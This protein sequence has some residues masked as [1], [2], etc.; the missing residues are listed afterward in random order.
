MRR[1]QR[2]VENDGLGG[3]ANKFNWRVRD[4]PI[5]RYE[6]HRGQHGRVG[7]IRALFVIVAVRMAKTRSRRIKHACHL[8]AIDGDHFHACDLNWRRIAS[9]WTGVAGDRHLDEKN[10]ADQELA[11]NAS[12]GTS[13]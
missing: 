2:R 9:T 12:N 8:V 7:V 10:D 6:Q 13:R 11:N 4:H 5:Q 3:F 1:R